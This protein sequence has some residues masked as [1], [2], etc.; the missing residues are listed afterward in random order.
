M[1]NLQPL[2]NES[3]QLLLIGMGTVFIILTMLI[4]LISFSSKL[5][6]RYEEEAPFLSAP[7]KTQPAEPVATSDDNQLVAVISSAI[8]AYKN[9]HSVK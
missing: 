5:L 9:K 1:E 6:S 4:F 7:V 8:R 3:V 2:I